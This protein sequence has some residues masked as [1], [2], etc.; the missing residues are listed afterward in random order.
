MKRNLS[1]IFLFLFAFGATMFAQTNRNLKAPPG[2]QKTTK[3]SVPAVKKQ[4]VTGLEEG[5]SS[6]VNIPPAENS[7]VDQVFGVT[8]YDLQSNSN[9]GSRIHNFGD[10]KVAGVWTISL[11][12]S[13]AAGFADRGTGY[14]STDNL[15]VAGA[16]PAAKVESVRTGFPSYFVDGGNEEWIFAHAAVPPST[17]TLQIHYAHRPVGGTTWT[18]G[19]VPFTTPNGGLW[20]RACAGGP[21][22]KTLH[23]IYLTTPVGNMGVLV[24]GL[25][26]SL[27]YSRSQNGGATWDIVDLAVPGIDATKWVGVNADAYSIDANGSTVAIGVFST[28]NDVLMI[29]SSDNGDSWDTPRVVNDFPLDHYR[30]GDAYDPAD[31]AAYIDPAI[32]PAPNGI[33]DTWAM[34]TTDGS[35]NV[36][37]DNDGIVHVVAPSLFIRDSIFDGTTA[38]NYYPGDLLGIIYWN[39]SMNDDEGIINAGAVDLDGDGF[40][41]AADSEIYADG[42]GD[43][44][45]SGASLG[46]DDEARLYVSYTAHHDLFRDGDNFHYRQPFV[47]RSEPGDYL[48]WNTP[49]TVLDFRIVGDTDLVK[50]SEN[51]F[52]SMAKK[53][54]NHVHVLWQQDYTLGLT[55]RITNN[56]DPLEN[57]IVYQAYPLEYFVVGTKEPVTKVDVSVSPNPTAGLAELRFQIDKSQDIQV[58]V[59]DAL[60]ALVQ[61]RSAFAPAG[62]ITVEVNT[63]AFANGLY[64]VR[65][66]GTNVAGQAK[67]MVAK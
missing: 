65:V 20:A 15:G 10:G 43:A 67:L 62:P 11:T 28:D 42:Y 63:S 52:A 1:L 5:T 25:D 4:A 34:L 19:N 58:E 54:D 41:G 3:P 33:I 46:M 24:D 53:V 55:L 44:F 2:F 7:F 31:V 60:G 47:N 29:K 26:G 9:L 13:E 66:N 30:I 18:E 32:W 57:N 39:E 17:V 50:F 59:F 40:W 36:L 49:Q 64:Y 21:D 38:Y 61:T 51:Y 37:V 48:S 14:N 8:T 12:G 27:R 6:P 35:G 16:P 23:V 56:Q 45:C 22:G